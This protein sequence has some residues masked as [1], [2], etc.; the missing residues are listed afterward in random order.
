[1]TASILG[2]TADGGPGSR[3][4]AGDLDWPAVEFMRNFAVKRLF[5][6]ENGELVVKLALLTN[7]VTLSLLAASYVAVE[8]GEARQDLAAAFVP[9]ARNIANNSAGALNSGDRANARQTLESLASDPRILGAALFPPESGSSGVPAPFASYGQI[10]GLERGLRLTP[11][12]NF[13][14][15]TVL[16]VEDTVSHEPESSGESAPGRVVLRASLDQ[17]RERLGHYSSIAFV[18]LAA[19]FSL[20]ALMSRR[21]AQ[22]ARKLRPSSTG[23]QATG[24]GSPKT[25]DAGSLNNPADSLNNPAG[26]P[27]NPDAGTLMEH[28][29]QRLETIQHRDRATLEQLLKSIA[30]ELQFAREAAAESARL[31]REFLS[32]MSHEIL[33]P[34]NGVLGMTSLALDTGL[35]PDAR[36]YLEAAN[37]SAETLLSM[38]RDIFDYSR[39]D[40]GKLALEAVPFHLRAVLGRLVRTLG[41]TAGKKGLE[42]IYEIDPAIPPALMG[43]PVRLQQVLANL[44]GN[45]IKFTRTGR[46]QLTVRLQNTAVGFPQ[47][48]ECICAI[49]FE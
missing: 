43:D 6:L 16:L 14:S 40:S 33:T 28:F 32:N 45:A 11:G 39:I 35:P 1:M 25:A 42:L 9:V 36:E 4:S 13:E 26:S 34:L 30:Q 5:G 18:A 10:S 8:Y 2:D 19:A 46:V 49:T 17:A 47:D 38:V 7:F 44:I 22:F 29:N 48:R 3:H 21:L 24:N 12:I 31:K 41:L 15:G 20:G 27:N 37:L 23:D